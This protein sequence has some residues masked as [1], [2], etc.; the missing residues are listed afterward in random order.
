[1]CLAQGC[2]FNNFSVVCFDYYT[3][4]SPHEPF[5]ADGSYLGALTSVGSLPSEYIFDMKALLAL[6][7][8]DIGC[9]G[10]R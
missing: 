4:N 10:N 3:I 1:M 6:D 5:S 9:V 2:F 8:N 7:S